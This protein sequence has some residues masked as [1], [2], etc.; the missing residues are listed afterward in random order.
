MATLVVNELT[1]YEQTVT[2]QKLPVKGFK[3]VEDLSEFD[4]GF[5]KSYNE[6]S[7]EGFFLEVDIPYPKKLHELHYDLPFLPE[8]MK[9]EKIK[10]L[11]ANLRVKMNT[12]FTQEI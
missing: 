7:K 12:L 4:E 3:W 1:R 8:G 10:K 11:L 2:S 5:I 9:N 6:K